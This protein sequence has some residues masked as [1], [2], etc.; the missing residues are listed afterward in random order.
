MG[1]DTV[2]DGTMTILVT[3]MMVGATVAV[4]NIMVDSMAV[5]RGMVVDGAAGTVV[6]VSRMVAAASAVMVVA[7]VTVAANACGKRADPFRNWEGSVAE[8]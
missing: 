2:I 7:E 1:T 5:M 3:T 6:A 8:R 4:E